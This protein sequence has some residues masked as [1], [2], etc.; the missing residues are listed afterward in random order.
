M[1]KADSQVCNVID[2]GVVRNFVLGEVIRAAVTVGHDG[3][4]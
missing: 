2:T 1:T 3:E 4:T